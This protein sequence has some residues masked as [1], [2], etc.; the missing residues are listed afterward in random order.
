MLTKKF[1]RVT[2]K[3]TQYITMLCTYVNYHPHLQKPLVFFKS[4]NST[5]L[6]IFGYHHEDN[7]HKYLKT[8]YHTRPLTDHMPDT[9]DTQTHTH[10][11]GTLSVVA[12]TVF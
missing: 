11:R 12:G 10:T 4:N 2:E 3:P 9:E 7:T 1:V 5:T 6:T 8:G